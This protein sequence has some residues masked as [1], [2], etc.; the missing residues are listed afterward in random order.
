MKPFFLLLTLAILTLPSCKKDGDVI[1]YSGKT[2]LKY[3]IISPA[4][5]IPL[6]VLKDSG[7]STT[8]FNPYF[9]YVDGG[10]GILGVNIE[11]Y[12][13]SYT[14][15]TKEIDVTNLKKPFAATLDSRSFVPII[16][17]QAKLNIYVNGELK[18][19]KNYPIREFNDS[20]VGVFDAL[21]IGGAPIAQYIIN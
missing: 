15:W 12:D 2:I 16:T 21:S 7:I 3:E 8:G 17:G 6:S 19:Q 5:T 14:T 11:Y 1:S 20:G 10:S 9:Y 18:A 13:Y 4:P